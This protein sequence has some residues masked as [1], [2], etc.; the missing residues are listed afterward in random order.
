[1]IASL[2]GLLAA[3]TTATADP[4]CAKSDSIKL[5]PAAMLEKEDRFRNSLS[6]AD[7]GRLDAALP[8]APSGR[9]A[10]CADHDGASCDAAAYLTALQSTGLMAAFLDSLCGKP[11]A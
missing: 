3:F 5:S 10:Q 4:Q 9:I 1:M 6:D 11:P 8:R 7:R 2:A